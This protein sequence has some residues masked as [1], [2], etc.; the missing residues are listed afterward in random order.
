MWNETKTELKTEGGE[1]TWITLRQIL[2]ELHQV[3]GFRIAVYDSVSRQEVCAWPEEILPLCRAIQK[4]S[5]GLKCCRENDEKAFDYV[6]KTGK[7]KI[8]RCHGGLYEAVA[9]LY[10]GDFLSGY[11]MMGQTLDSRKFSRNQVM[12]RAEEFV[13][14]KEQLE[15]L[16]DKIPDRSLEQIRSCI[17]IMEI[18]AGYITLS[19]RYQTGEQRPI[20]QVRRYLEENYTEEITI[21]LLCRMFHMS[22][23]SLTGEFRQAWGT[24]IH[25]YVMKLRLDQAE[26]LL[27]RPGLSIGEIAERCGFSDPNYFTRA[28]RK[29]YGAA[30]SQYRKSN[31]P[32]MS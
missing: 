6:E 28:F 24:S 23:A 29:R 15:K 27:N 13:P 21:D 2:R 12:H 8:Y 11:L 26:I 31:F 17:R 3:S 30:P 18:C 1:S 25:Q 32:K 20:W 16:V 14:E 4:N 22:R 5:Q 19:R 9:P 10:D 7:V